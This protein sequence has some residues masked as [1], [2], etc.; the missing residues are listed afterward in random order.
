MTSCQKVEAGKVLVAAEAR[1]AALA[2]D[3]VHQ[4]IQG[5]VVIGLALQAI[6][7]VAAAAMHR[8]AARMADL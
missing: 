8:L 2:A 6:H 1:A 7:P 4:A 5:Q 3:A